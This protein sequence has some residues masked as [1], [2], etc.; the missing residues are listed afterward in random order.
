MKHERKVL[1]EPSLRLLLA[2]LVGDSVTLLRMRELQIDWLLL[3]MR[4]TVNM[5]LFCT[6]EPQSH[7]C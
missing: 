4:K 7:H 6:H 2:D 1:A 3:E 5:S